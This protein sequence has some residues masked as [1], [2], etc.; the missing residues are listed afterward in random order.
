MKNFR[1]NCNFCT[2]LKTVNHEWFCKKAEL[3]C[4]DLV[5][6]PYKYF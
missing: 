5:G 1:E 4:K 3:P 2:E 6:C